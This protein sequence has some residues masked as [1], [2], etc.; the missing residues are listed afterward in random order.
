M[1]EEAVSAIIDACTSPKVLGFFGEATVNVLKVNLM[2]D[3]VLH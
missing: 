2:L 1:S 3:G